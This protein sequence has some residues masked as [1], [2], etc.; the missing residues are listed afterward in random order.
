MTAAGFRR[1]LLGAGVLTACLGSAPA[2][3]A[4]ASTQVT[5]PPALSAD[6]SPADI[7]STRGSGVFGQWTVDGFG[8]P[9]YRYQVDET[10][11][12]RA[13]QPELAGATRAQHQVG[14]DHIVAAAFN[15]GYTQLWSQ[16]R[17]SQWAN[18]YQPSNQHY[19]GGYGYLNVDGKVAST[20][21]LDR[22]AGAP[23]QRDFGV[24]Y[25][26]KQLTFAGVDVTQTVYAPFGDDPVLLDDVTLR[27]TTT[28]AKKVSWFE[29][30]DV[31]PFDQ[32][33]VGNQTRGLMAPT[34]DAASRTL[35]VAQFGNDYRD[36]AQLSIFAAALSGPVDGYETSLTP[37]F[38]S[39]GR[40]APTEVT[41]DHLSGTIAPANPPG[42][43]GSTLF[44][45]RAPVTLAPGQSITLR[46]VY[47]M[48]HPEQIA[49]LVSKYRSADDPYAASERSWARWLPRADFGPTNTWVA[50]ELAW[51]AYLLRSATVYEELC[52][53]HTITQGGY[54]EY[55]DGYNLGFRSWP[56]YLLPITYTDPGLAR[57]ILRYSI[58]LQPPGGTA[59]GYQFPYGTGQLCERVD[60]GTS[61]DLDFWLLNAAAEYGMGMRDTHFFD[62]QL[63]FYG[64]SVKVSAWEHIKLAFAH[65]ES[66][67]GPHGGYLTG[68]TGDWSDFSTQFLQ[69]T[70]SMLVTAQLAY[71]YPRL[72]QL[73][74]L[75]GDTAFAAQLR[76]AGAHDL[77][78]L[79]AEWT[80]KGW[81]S[82]GYSGN[83]QIGQGV[84][85]GEPQ[86]WAI[87]AG[88]P[89][90]PQAN[91]L[92]ANIRRFLTGVGAPASL[93][94]P[95]KNGS[96][97]SPALADPGITERGPTPANSVLPVPDAFG[98]VP[99]NPLQGGS[100]WPG[101][102]W[103]DV[104]GWLTWSLGELDGVVPQARAYAW[105]EY[106]RNTLATHA[107]AFPDHWD[108]TIS[109]DDVCFAYYSST[110]SYCG[111][112]LS[113][114]YSGQITEQATWMVMDAIRLAGI[115]PVGTGYRIVPHLPMNNFSLRLPQ[116]GVASEPGVL[117]GYLRPEQSGSVQMQV[118]APP[119]TDVHRLV[120]FADGRQ[121]PSTVQDGL[122][123]FALATQA[124]RSA[125]W[126]VVAP[127]TAA[128][129]GP[130]ARCSS[131]RRF[132][133]RL[134]RVRFHLRRATL[135][136]NGRRVRGVR[137]S[138][139]RVPV[140][141]RGRPPGTYHVLIAGVTRSGQHVTI[142]R[143]YHT[144][145]R[146][147]TGPHHTGRPHYHG[148]RH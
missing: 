73:A 81:Y 147:R 121:V 34:W 79:R 65:Q 39:G 54:Y 46:Y 76:A 86:P 64:T 19:A 24:G 13:A 85:F 20:L 8:M 17:L 75:R 103:F 95:A 7:A 14:N 124:G 119:G 11:D 97:I 40:A 102:V 80:G 77:A 101:G 60:L 125:D 72:A 132:N 45:F 91:T 106:I 113:Y 28:A 141:L 130:G 55:G 128:A 144:C 110:P 99:H 127:G 120:A 131:R 88:A 115:T 33:I 18:L 137:G 57:E 51:D 68:A 105:D 93:G 59:N 25:Y 15:D 107:T 30:W 12:P 56:H 4:A 109:V 136:V 87:L 29:Y 108:G 35:A 129:G 62:E 22:P 146:R 118:A 10:R 49:G 69:M 117:R 114:S 123:T 61:D 96:A 42:Q 37:F 53:Q 1:L 6:Q 122:V 2:A 100:E 92:V 44:A 66:L 36:T 27:N 52:G 9:A 133:V 50:R 143:T 139:L 148:R 89:S 138:P 58:D 83:R 32:A 145:V 67:L 74:D 5:A 26:R 16:D 70:E 43:N 31:N 104:N 140:D 63:P 41:A 78:T 71:A 47:G 134:G 135:Y 82:R 112:G 126:A 111:N 3:R 23:F 48:A 116:I 98:I 94:G 38:G 142:R 90:A 21:Y 84:I